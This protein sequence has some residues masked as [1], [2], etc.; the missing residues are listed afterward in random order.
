MYGKDEAINERGIILYLGGATKIYVQ[1]IK[2]GNSTGDFVGVGLVPTTRKG[3]A[4][5]EVP[6]VHAA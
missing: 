3:P 4:A 2:I 1:R 6:C 5:V